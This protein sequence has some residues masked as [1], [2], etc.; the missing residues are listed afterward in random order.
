[1]T[2]SR[3]SARPMAMRSDSRARVLELVAGRQDRAEQRVVHRVHDCTRSPS[4]RRCTLLRLH[5]VRQPCARAAQSVAADGSRR[6]RAGSPIVALA[7]H[8]PRPGIPVRRH[9]PGAGRSSPGRGG[10]LVA[11]ADEALGEP[12]CRL[13]WEGPADELD[14]TVNAQPAL[15]A[16][17]IASHAGARGRRSADADGSALR[18]RRFY[19]GHS[20]GQ[21][22]AMVAAGVICARRRRAAGPRARPADAG[23]GRRRR[24]GGDHRPA[25]RATSPSSR[26]PVE[27][28]GVFTIANRNSPGPDRGQRRA[29]RRRGA[30][31]KPPGSWA[32]SAPSCCRS[33][34]PR[35]RR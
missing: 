10:R 18:R 32:P 3:H 29:R 23:V 22:S 6:H 8:L 21:Y 27:A 7:V 35:T 17:S 24:D 14:L 12:I 20:M 2:S 25:R 13:A 34:S 30:A 26:P 5:V 15:L 16:A 4:A 11:E 1:M 9:G 19:A 28:L 33:A 31:E